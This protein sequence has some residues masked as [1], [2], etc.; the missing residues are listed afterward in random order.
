MR[1]S[2]RK[3]KSS[4]KCQQGPPPPTHKTKRTFMRTTIFFL[5]LTHM[6]KHRANFHHLARLGWAP[7]PPKE[8]N[9]YW[10]ADLNGVSKWCLNECELGTAGEK[11]NDLWGSA[12]ESQGCPFPHKL[13]QADG[14]KP[15]VSVTWLIVALRNALGISASSGQLGMRG[16][17]L[18]I[19]LPGMG[20]SLL[21]WNSSQVACLLPEDV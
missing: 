2:A 18:F 16:G 8:E 21:L 9:V 5:Y 10:G 17:T 7:S 14:L 20:L 19:Q 13:F 6:A 4:S 1:T 11:F 12:G 15:G 3:Q